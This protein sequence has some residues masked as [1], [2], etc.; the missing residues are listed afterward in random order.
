LSSWRGHPGHPKAHPERPWWRRHER[1]EALGGFLPSKSVGWIHPHGV[2]AYGS[3]AEVVMA[4]Y[5]KTHPIECPEP[6]CGQVWQNDSGDEMLVTKVLICVEEKLVYFNGRAWEGPWP[7]PSMCLVS[8]TH[9][10]WKNTGEE[11]KGEK[12]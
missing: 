6:R 8:G 7:P 9:S 1:E 5:D 11:T 12:E 3:D 10:P 4:E 2:F